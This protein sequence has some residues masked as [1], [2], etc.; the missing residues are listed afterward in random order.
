MRLCVPVPCFFKK[1]DFCDAIR[2]I[3]E[4]GFDAAETYKWEGL[5]FDRVK[6]TCFEAGVE[7][8]S[9]CTKEFRLTDPAYR[10]AFLKG[11]EKSCEAANKMG[12]KRL[13]TQVGN[14]TGEPREAQHASIVK[15]L[16]MARDILADS[17]VTVMI[18]PLN[19]LYDHVG[20]YLPSAIEG[21]SIVREVGSPFVKVVYDIYHQQVGEGNIINNITN[22]LDSI[23]HLHAAGHP[24]RHELQFGESDYKNIF[25][26]L[27]KSGYKG[28]CGLE[29]SPTMNPV[30]SLIKAKEIYGNN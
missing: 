10:D 26:S 30:E 19:N 18:E 1:T 29:Y 3:A 8:L 6:D 23:A 17:G 27:D 5:D 21:F 16:S 4:L 20:Y 24:G 2:K 7:L 15:T 28:A 22:N 13:I 12:V 14:D 25:A 11:L 9:M